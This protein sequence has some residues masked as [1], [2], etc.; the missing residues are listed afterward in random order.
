MSSNRLKAVVPSLYLRPQG[1]HFSRRQVLAMFALA[2]GGLV[3]GCSVNPATGQRQLMLM[4]TAQEQAIDQQ[5]SPHQISADYGLIQ[6]AELTAYVK[7][8]GE[9]IGQVSHRPEMPYQYLALNANYINAYAFPGGTIGV[10]RGILLD[11]ESEAELAALLGHEVAH[12]SARHTAQRMTNQTLIGVAVAGAGVALSTQVDDTATALALGLGGIAAGALLARYSRGDERQADALGLEYMTSAGYS[13]EGMV[14]LMDLLQ[15]LSSR[16]PSMLEQMFSSH[17]MSDERYRD[18]QR[19]AANRYAD[20]ANQPL[21]RE[22]YMDQTAAL[23]RLKPAVALQQQ[24]E[25][26]LGRG[27]QWQAVQSLQQSLQ[28]APDDYA[29]LVLLGKAWLAKEEYE[30]ARGPLAEA[31][32]VYPEEA[33]AQHLLGVIAL[34]QEQPERALNQF[35]N[36]HRLLPGNPM[37]DFFMG[38][39]YEGLS[40]SSEA[41]AAYQRFLNQGGSGEASRYAQQRLAEWSAI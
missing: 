3:T 39:S 6:D 41:A 7:R 31:A 37:T 20:K 34:Q 11:M 28:L 18:A 21:Y 15:S 5:H 27:E 12:V 16:Q 2:S 17:P 4:S 24:A 36:Y 40:Q 32:Q 29:G 22:R 38:L 35:K 10:T 13:P 1:R 19:E 9:G 33:Q 8:V 25:A 14:H 26:Q 23:R 30:K